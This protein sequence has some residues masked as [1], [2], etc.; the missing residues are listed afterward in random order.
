MAALLILMGTTPRPVV[1]TCVVLS[2]AVMGVCNTLFTELALEISGAPRPVASAGYNCLRWF[3][4]VIAPFAVPKIAEFAGVEIAFGVAAVAV[5]LGPV[6]FALRRSHLARPVPA[7][8]TAVAPLMAT[9][10]GGAGD[11]RV[12]HRAIGLALQRGQ[13]V[14]AVHVSMTEVFDEDEADLEDSATAKSITDAALRRLR[15]AGVHAEAR[16]VSA[17]TGAAA[18]KV[19]EMSRA[20]G[21]S[22][23][24]VGAPHRR[25]LGDVMHGSFTEALVSISEPHKILVIEEEAAISEA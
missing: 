16:I 15:D 18:R 2:G 7:E 17:S 20:L 24:I 8:P 21:A 14:V 1:A 11:A 4:G 5:L 13:P 19:L 12:L 9:V 3:A 10:D 25:D 22:L 23:I 6:T